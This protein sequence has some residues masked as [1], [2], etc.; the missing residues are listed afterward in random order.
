MPKAR[1]KSVR[2]SAAVKQSR[3]KAAKSLRRKAASKVQQVSDGTGVFQPGT[4]AVEDQPAKRAVSHSKD[5]ERMRA[6]RA[7][8]KAALHAVRL[9]QDPPPLTPRQTAEALLDQALLHGT[10]A[11]TH[12]PHYNKGQIEVWDYTTDQG[13]GFLEGNIVKYVSRWRHKDGVT[14]LEKARDYL[15][16]LIDVAKQVP[17]VDN[18]VAYR[19]L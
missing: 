5:A 1:R 17:S 18:A 16:K 7:K 9:D 2:K 4:K 6:S 8:S 19:P 10:S 14:D 12:P 15:N 3:S 11:V 13:M